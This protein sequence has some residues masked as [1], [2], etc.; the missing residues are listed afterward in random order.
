MSIN[1]RVDA[2]IASASYDVVV[3]IDALGVS[4]VEEDLAAAT[5]AYNEDPAAVIEAAE[6]RFTE[7][8]E[9]AVS[10]P[11]EE[12]AEEATLRARAAMALKDRL[13]GH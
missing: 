11:S 9:V 3:P 7:H 13:E 1:E 5:E 12:D 10:S 2:A 8:M 4:F 6:T